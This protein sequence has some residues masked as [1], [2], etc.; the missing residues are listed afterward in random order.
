MESA[1][2]PAVV[3]AVATEQL[4]VVTND[5]SL[6][7]GT[8]RVVA[9]LASLLG[10][11]FRLT[12][13]TLEGGKCLYP[14]AEEVSFVCIGTRRRGRNRMFRALWLPVQSIRLARLVRL[15]R[16]KATVSFLARSNLINVL[17]HLFTRSYKCVLFERNF[18]S[19]QYQ[20]GLTRPLLRIMRILYRRADLVLANAER[21]ARDLEGNFAVPGYKIGVV[22]NPINV[23]RVRELS[24][25]GGL[26]V[27]DMDGEIPFVVSVGRLVP[28][29]NHQLLLESFALARR[30]V[31]CHLV[32]LGEGPLRP[33]L[34][35][36]AERLGIR[37]DVFLLGW[38]D[39]P[40]KYMLRARLFVLASDYEGFPNVLLEAMTCGCAV[41]ATN[42]PG[43]SAEILGH[44]AFGVV[45]PPRDAA[46]LSQA[47]IAVLT[48]DGLRE[49]LVNA[50]LVRVEDFQAP[51]ILDQ[52][53]TA[54]WQ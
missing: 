30:S 50:A 15:L 49:R 12:L 7:G 40:Y 39:N 25:D 28:Q 33:E 46:A 36:L 3:R 54:I 53:V 2:L 1:D 42:S 32:L 22:H 20:D 47:M 24:Q 29:K 10:Q 19:I 17:A 8:Q 38:E 26:R 6:K 44:G 48:D 43:G 34:E 41:I 18:N 31:V 16:P 5:M 35:L 27:P 4:L 21:L 51:R 13:V 14:L 23:D 9:D 37:E 11:R 52:F 45:V